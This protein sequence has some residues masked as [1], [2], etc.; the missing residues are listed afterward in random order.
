[1]GG[2]SW[3]P[4]ITQQQ[5]LDLCQQTRGVFEMLPPNRFQPMRGKIFEITTREKNLA[6]NESLVII[7]TTVARGVETLAPNESLVIIMTT[8]A[9]GVETQRVGFVGGDP[10]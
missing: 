7:V 5:P 3:S 10:S 4:S 2:N 1:M 9:R 8:V 6:P